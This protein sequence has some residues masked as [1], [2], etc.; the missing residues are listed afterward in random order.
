MV[1]MWDDS[2]ENINLKKASLATTPGLQYLTPAGRFLSHAWN[3]S[4]SSVHPLAGHEFAKV[5]PSFPNIPFFP[6]VVLIVRLCKKK[7][8]SWSETF[9]R[10]WLK[11]IGDVS[12]GQWLV[13]AKK[14]LMVELSSSFLLSPVDTKMIKRNFKFFSYFIV[15]IVHSTATGLLHGKA[16]EPSIVYPTQG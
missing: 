5:F 11:I 2:N 3:L 6:D 12:L 15:H 7:N 14:R 13:L 16:Q 10:S 9:L 8:R 4:N 1:V